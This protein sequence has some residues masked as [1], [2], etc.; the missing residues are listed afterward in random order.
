MSQLEWG[1][2]KRSVEF[3]ANIIINEKL[4]DN[5][6]KCLLEGEEILM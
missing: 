3:G 4:V 5:P 2:L 1:S 6:V